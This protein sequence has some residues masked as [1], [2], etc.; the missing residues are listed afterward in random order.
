MC[1]DLANVVIDDTSRFF[2]CGIIAVLTGTV[3]RESKRRLIV[4]CDVSG[5]VQWIEVFYL[6]KNCGFTLLNRVPFGKFNRVNT[7]PPLEGTPMRSVVAFEGSKTPGYPIM[8]FLE[9]Q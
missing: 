1:P 8:H 9:I 3:C 2:I 6:S 7:C 5:P 4:R